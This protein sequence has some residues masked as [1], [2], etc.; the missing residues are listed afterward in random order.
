M[1]VL[2]FPNGAHGCR[3]R[4]YFHPAGPGAVRVDAATLVQRRVLRHRLLRREWASRNL[5]L[6]SFPS[7]TTIH[8]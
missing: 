8:P 7:L 3:S 6:G 5:G 2:P 4:G 1:L